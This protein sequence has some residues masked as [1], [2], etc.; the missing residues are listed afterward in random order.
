M[1]SGEH[2]R[3]QEVS[4][5]AKPMISITPLIMGKTAFS[6]MLFA[7]GMHYLSTGRSEAD[8]SRMVSGAVLTLASVFI[9][10]L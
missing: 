3:P 8:L 9:F 4:G 7:M 5:G 1:G 2:G 6:V 10:I